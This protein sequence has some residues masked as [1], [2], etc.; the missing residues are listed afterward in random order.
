ME[1]NNIGVESELTLKEISRLIDWLKAQ[2]F[3]S[4]KINE[5]IQYIANHKSKQ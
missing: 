2:G 5:C 1:E 4:E 3:T